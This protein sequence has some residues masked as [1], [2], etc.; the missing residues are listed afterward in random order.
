MAFKVLEMA[1]RLDGLLRKPLMAI[2]RHN[3]SL[4]G[5]LDR[6]MPGVVMQLAESTGRNGADRTHLVRNAAGSLCEVVAGVRLAL[7]REYLR[8]ADVAEAV[9][10][11]DEIGAILYTLAP[12]R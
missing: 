9:R 5:Q 6:A 10:L 12:R 11:A 4:E 3:R 8:D 2:R 1:I 7:N